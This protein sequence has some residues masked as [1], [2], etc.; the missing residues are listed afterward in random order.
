MTYLPPV[1]SVGPENTRK[2]VNYEV[3]NVYPIQASEIPLNLLLELTISF[4]LAPQNLPQNQET[5]S[6]NDRE[7]DWEPDNE[8]RILS[9]RLTPTFVNPVSNHRNLSPVSNSETK[10]VEMGALAPEMMS[11]S[12]GD[13]DEWMCS[14]PPLGPAPH[15]ETRSPF[16]DDIEMEVCWES[17]IM[18]EVYEDEDMLMRDWADEDVEMAEVV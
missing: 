3:T 2:D 1:P 5:D 10:D 11:P 14:P 17:E 16:D 13:L 18:L 9:P 12:L 8:V 6:P 15:I 7:A 4:H